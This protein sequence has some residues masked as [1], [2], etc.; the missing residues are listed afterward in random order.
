M[1]RILDGLPSSG[2]LAVAFPTE[3]GRLG[4]E[5]IVVQF[6]SGQGDLW[7]ANFKSGIGGLD[8][9]ILHP[10]GR[11]SIVFA[12]GDAWSVDPDARSAEMLAPAI[13][14]RWDVLDGILL[15][16]QSLAF[17]RVGPSGVCW[18]TRRLSWDGFDQIHISEKRLTGLAWSPVDD[19]FT[20]FSVDLLTGRADGGS[21]D[22][23]DAEGWEKLC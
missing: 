3:W 18:H 9:V 6:Q 15:S 8:E 23:C 14:A 17:L 13:E 12:G 16:R 4:R 7:T 21:Y 2:P 11:R 5:G 1:H 19:S 10:D 22:D 20:P